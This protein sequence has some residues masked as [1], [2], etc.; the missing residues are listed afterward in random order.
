[1]EMNK[2]GF[3]NIPDILEVATLFGPVDDAQQGDVGPAMVGSVP[4]AFEQ[5]DGTVNIPTDILGMAKGFGQNC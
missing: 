3:I 4:W 2:D 1:M 5:W